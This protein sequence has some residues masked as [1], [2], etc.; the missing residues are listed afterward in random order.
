MT[1]KPLEEMFEELTRRDIFEEG[2]DQDLT[3]FINRA[4]AADDEIVFKGF[5][6]RGFRRRMNSQHQEAYRDY[7]QAL[8]SLEEEV[9]MNAHV[10]IAD[11]L[12]VG[13]DSLSPLQNLDIAL[14]HIDMALEIGHEYDIH[15]IMI[16]KVH[17]QACRIY[18]AQESYSDAE[19]SGTLAVQE[20]QGDPSPEGLKQYGLAAHA[21]GQ[22]YVGLH[23]FEAALVYQGKALSSF[24]RIGEDVG[25]MNALGAMGE[26][27][28]MRENY[29][30]AAGHFDRSM[31]VM[32]IKKYPRALAERSLRTAEAYLLAGDEDKGM[33]WVH[34]FGIAYNLGG[35][36]DADRRIHSERFM[37]VGSMIRDNGLEKPQWWDE[38]AQEF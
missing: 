28:I 1:D 27:E 14:R 18:L 9:V 13:P 23:D 15:G 21:L 7:Q 26:L 22:A 37:A 3:E 17:H 36:T 6:Y 10:N 38:V 16:S 11:V 30:E 12:R 2:L 24:R 29:A 19:C 32:D 31:R 5:N 33:H 20:V 35:F 34:E 25:A 8:I 4:W